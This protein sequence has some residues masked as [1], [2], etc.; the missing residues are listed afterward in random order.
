MKKSLILKSTQKILLFLVTITLL[1][2]ILNIYI[3]NGENEVIKAHRLKSSWLVGTF[4]IAF[5]YHIIFRRKKE[6]NQ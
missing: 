1:L 3:N 2:F 6:D 4:A 5:F